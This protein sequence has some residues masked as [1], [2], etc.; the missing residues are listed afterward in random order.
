MTTFEL[1]R[2]Q[3]LDKQDFQNRIGN[4]IRQL[5]EAQKISQVELAHLCNFEKSNMN[6]IEAG[7]TSTNTF[8]LYKICLAL[9]I[10]M[11]EFFSF[12]I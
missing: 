2:I 1:Y 12:E 3:Q 8:T 6:R 9:G 4:R 10:S 11:K 5:R 7:N